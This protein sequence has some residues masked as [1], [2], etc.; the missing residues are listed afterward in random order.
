M[1]RALAWLRLA[2]A[3]AWVPAGAVE[4]QAGEVGFATVQ[5]PD[6]PGAALKV[7][8]WYPTLTPGSDQQISLFT[9]HVAPDAAI[10]GGRHALVVMSHGNGG[11]LDNHYDTALALAQAGFVVAAMTHT[12]DNYQDQSRAT[13]LAD[14]PR[15]VHAVIGFMLSDWSGAAAINPDQV[16]MFGFSSGALTTLVAIAAS[17]ISARSRATAR[18]TRRPMSAS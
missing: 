4:V 9:Q 16:G 12:G 10:A 11:S 13:E 8:I 7:G 6:P 15:A 2:V 18:A 14:R 3:L 1:P 17:P 5:V